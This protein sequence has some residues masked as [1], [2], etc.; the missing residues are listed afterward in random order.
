MVN[1]NSF[2]KYINFSLFNLVVVA[3]Y[4][5]LMRYKI[6]FEFPFLDQKF[7]Q[8]AHS[9]FAFSGWITQTL[10]VLM[11]YVLN[12]VCKNISLKKYKIILNAN[13]VCAYGML[14]SF[15]F[16]G[17]EPISIIFSTLSLFVS[18]L[19]AYIFI[20]DSTASNVQLSGKNWFTAAILFNILSAAGTLVLGYMMATKNLNQNLYLSS[21]YYYLHFQ[22]NGWFFFACMGLLVHAF[23]AAIPTYRENKSVFKLFAGACIPAYFLSVLFLNPPMW[24]Y[25]ILV[26]SALAQAI[27]WFKFLQTANNHRKEIM[28]KTSLV[29]KYLILFVVTAVTIKL[30]LQLF[31]TI[32]AI[33]KLAFGFRTIVIAY[34]HLVLLAI[35]S[36]FLI[37]YIYGSGLISK[38]K[39]TV[40]AILIFTIGI[41]LNELLLLIQGVASF[42]Y[43]L[44]PFSNELLFGISVV[45]L[46]GSLIL[47]MSNLNK[48]IKNF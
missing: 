35:F 27:G 26:F 47:F 12:G 38:S 4:G 33:S 41:F 42:S 37:T 13:L 22:Y 32:P 2:R 20:K 9:H 30:T 5:V 25:T 29:M 17:Y 10:M 1:G 23:S 6:G 43:T 15:T 44:I 14:V 31:S 21:V 28:Q 48:I 3:L 36:T 19:F 40:S 39:L 8:H 7:L 18:F 16:T 45:L 46:L 24:L 11:I 34:L